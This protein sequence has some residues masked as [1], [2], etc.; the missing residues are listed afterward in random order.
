MKS[1]VLIADDNKPIRDVLTRMLSGAP[2]PC[3]VWS[4]SDGAQAL[5]LA[6]QTNPDLILLDLEMPGQDGWSVLKELRSSERT[7]GIPIILVSGHGEVATRIGGFNGGAD[8]FVS[9]PFSCPE[10]K[11]RVNRLLHRVRQDI[12]TSP[13]TRLPGNPAIEDEVS[14]RIQERKPFAFFYVDIDNFKSYND[15]YGFAEG[16]RVIQETARMLDQSLGVD[17]SGRFLGHIGGDDFVMMSEPQDALHIAKTTATRFDRC[18][19]DY[20]GAADRANGFVKVKD[21][22][23]HLRSFPLVTLSIGIA[24][25]QLRVFNRYSEVVAVASE[26]KTYLKLNPRPGFSRFAYERRTD[27]ASIR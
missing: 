7:R 12:S 8:D 6:E 1:K 16:D 21:R 13:L 5:A 25:T 11:A 24:T 9:K 22:L 23:G 4:A 17:R 19:R 15:S 27:D 10:L 3:E 26:M 14:R 20:Y 2:E 18:A